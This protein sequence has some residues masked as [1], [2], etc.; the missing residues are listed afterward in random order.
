MAIAFKASKLQLFSGALRRRRNLIFANLHLFVPQDFV[1]KPVPSLPLFWGGRFYIY[2]CI[3][4]YMYIYIYNPMFFSKNGG[5]DWSQKLETWTKRRSPAAR[6]FLGVQ[7]NVSTVRPHHLTTGGKQFGRPKGFFSQKKAKMRKDSV[8]FLFLVLEN[9][10][11]KCPK[12]LIVTKCINIGGNP[13]K[14]CRKV[15]IFARKPLVYC[16]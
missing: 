14:C 16:C 12:C 10:S 9:S 4:I 5:V 6:A 1:T 3:Y 13:T 7:P 15:S 8:A 2:T 11:Q